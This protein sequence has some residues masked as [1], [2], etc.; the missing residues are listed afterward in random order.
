M[1]TDV[2]K[3][4]AWLTRAVHDAAMATHGTYAKLARESDQPHIRVAYALA[5]QAVHH[6]G[7]EL[8]AALE[9]QTPPDARASVA[10]S[11]T[12]E[13]IDVSLGPD[14]ETIRG[15]RDPRCPFHGC[16][17]D[18]RQPETPPGPQ[19]NYRNCPMWTAGVV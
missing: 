3:P 15:R 1:V 5:G 7:Q 14:Q 18:P 12:C 13:R 19:H 16:Q 10:V 8:I 6:F 4:Y 17:C 2:P 9:Q 11:C